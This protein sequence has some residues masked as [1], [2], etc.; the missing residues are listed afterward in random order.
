MLNISVYWIVSYLLQASNGQI[1]QS[2]PV[3]YLI[4]GDS[5]IGSLTDHLRSGMPMTRQ[6]YS[7]NGRFRELHEQVRSALRENH[8]TK[9]VN[10]DV[11]NLGE[12]IL[13]SST[14]TE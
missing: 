5:R 12:T 13:K 2:E 9:V 8:I 10:G 11:G 1:A 4:I 14:K 6:V 3:K 7:L